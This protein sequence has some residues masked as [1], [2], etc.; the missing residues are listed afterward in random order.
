M[1]NALVR[2]PVATSERRASVTSSGSATTSHTGKKDFSDKGSTDGKTAATPTSQRAPVLGLRGL[3]A[4]KRLTRNLKLRSTARQ[5][6]GSSFL[7]FSDRPKAK[8]LTPRVTLQP[9]YRLEPNNVFRTYEPQIFHMMSGLIDSR[10]DGA[11]YDPKT[12]AIQCR[13]LS[14]EIK[15][16]IKGLEI[17]RYRVIVIVNIGAIA[18]QG[19]SIGSRAVWDTTFDTFI[20]Y[21]YRNPSLFC[22]ATVYGVYAE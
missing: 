14:D 22:V 3:L 6:R 4:A 8:P 10:F 20:T 2:K 15:D 19:I 11:K 12:S 7:S 13:L 1:M 21:E 18:N 16:W 9:T 17:E 5:L